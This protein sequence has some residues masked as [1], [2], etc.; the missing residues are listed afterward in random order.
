MRKWMAFWLSLLL[1]AGCTPHGGRGEATDTQFLMDTVCT[2]TAGGKQGKAAVAAAM[3]EIR[4]IQEVA[5]FYQEGSTV[6]RF[7]RSKA[8]EAVPIDPHTEAMVSVAL[9]ISR[10]SEGA[11]DITIAPVSRLW[12]FHGEESPTPPDPDLLERE[13]S[14]VGWEALILDQENHT[15]TKTRDGVE[16]DLGGAAKGY[17]A[18]RA[19]AVLQES[20]AEYGILNLGGNVAVFGENPHRR[21]GSWQV[22]LQTPFGE[23]GEYAETVRLEG[24]GAVVTAG[25]YQRCFTYQGK[26]YHHILDPTRG[27]PAESRIDGVTI[28]ADSGLLADCLSTACLVLGKE[29]GAKLAQDYG[30]LRYETHRN[31]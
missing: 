16:I 25:T 1:L 15:L 27:M 18:D 29:K 13:R 30:V 8:G 22:G 5:D 28:V 20:G 24:S 14:K 4:R 10:A 26:F 7:N 19:I 3:E 6:S 23:A 31:K 9:E 21:D 11:F 12:P 17:A 2:I